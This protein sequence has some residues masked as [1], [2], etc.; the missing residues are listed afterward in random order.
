[1]DFVREHHAGEMARE[2][3]AMLAAA[4]AVTGDRAAVDTLWR[5]ADGGMEAYA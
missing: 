4:F 3:R 1:M 2:W 5:D